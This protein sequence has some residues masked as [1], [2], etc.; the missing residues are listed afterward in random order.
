MSY[1]LCGLAHSSEM[2]SHNCEKCLNLKII[3]QDVL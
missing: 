2:I 3:F 1:V